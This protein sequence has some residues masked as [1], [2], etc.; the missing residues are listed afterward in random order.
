MSFEHYLYALA[1]IRILIGLAPMVAIGPLSR[2]LGFPEAHNTP[3]SRLMA[4]F[5]G[6]R[7]MGL[8]V[9]AIAALHGQASVLFVCLFNLGHD[10]FDTV[11]ILTPLVRRQ[12]IDRAAWSSLAFALGG[13]ACWAFAAFWGLG[14][15]WL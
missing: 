5:F 15:L 7:D 11:W 6:V 13:A 3:T 1:A 2:L 4:R 9:L 8:G 10:L 14:P 12:G